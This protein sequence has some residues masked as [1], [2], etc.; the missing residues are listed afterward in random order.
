MPT[1]RQLLTDIDDRMPNTFTQTQKVRWMNDFQNQIWRWMASTELYEFYTIASQ[2]VYT[3]NDNIRFDKIQSVQI[4]ASTVIDGTEDY[5][6]Y[7]YAGYDDNL[8]GQQYY[9]SLDNMGIYPTPDTTNKLVKIFYES[10]PTQ[11]S[12]NTL[13]TEVDLNPE[14]QDVLKFRAM[15]VMA[16]SGN[17]PDIELANNYQREEEEIVKQIRMDYYKKKQRNPKQQWSYKKGWWKG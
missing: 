11:L 10:Y 3:L 16:Q 14:Y 2:A 7:N 12:T 9:D 4:S 6:Q 17:A 8:T 1:V 5:V 13:D 15:K